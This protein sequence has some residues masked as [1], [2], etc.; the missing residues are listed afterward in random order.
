MQTDWADELL[1]NKLTF[2]STNSSV[3]INFGNPVCTYS[4][5]RGSPVQ[6]GKV[7]RAVDTGAGAMVALVQLR[8]HMPGLQVGSVCRAG[9]AF[10]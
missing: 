10:H 2:C 8:A 7:L 5:V 9:Y 4:R 3:F 6:G 1:N